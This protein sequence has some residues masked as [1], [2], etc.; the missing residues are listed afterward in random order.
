MTEKKAHLLAMPLHDNVEG[1]L[2][3]INQGVE[4]AI[5]LRE[6]VKPLL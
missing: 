4:L 5:F 6:V 3:L 2:Q 1:C